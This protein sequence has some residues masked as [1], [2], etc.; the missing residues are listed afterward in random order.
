MEHIADFL[1]SASSTG[2]NNSAAIQN[3]VSIK[4]INLQG[5][6]LSFDAP[7]SYAGSRLL[8]F[9]EMTLFFFQAV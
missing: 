7:R 6:T 8:P 1:L 3:Y 4:G 9:L 2:G 5:D